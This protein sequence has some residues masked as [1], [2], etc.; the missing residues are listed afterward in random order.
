MS[1]AGRIGRWWMWGSCDIEVSCGGQ[2]HHVRPVDLEHVVLVDH[3]TDDSIVVAL[4]AFKTPCYRVADSWRTS[5]SF[6]ARAGLGPIRDAIGGKE[7]RVRSRWT[8]AGL[9]VKTLMSV[10]GT[11]S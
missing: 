7:V 5:S 3:E 4:G 2:Q 10:T 9:P 8:V 11:P 6:G 1:I